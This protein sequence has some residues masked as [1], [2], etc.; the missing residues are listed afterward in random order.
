MKRSS[1]CSL[2]EWVPVS[3][4]EP[5][6]LLLLVLP[7]PRRSGAGASAPRPGQGTGTGSSSG[8]SARLCL[9]PASDRLPWEDS[10]EVDSV[11]EVYREGIFGSERLDFLL[12]KK[13]EGC[14]APSHLARDPWPRSVLG[15]PLSVLGGRLAMGSLC[16]QE[17]PKFRVLPPPL[18]TFL[19]HVGKRRPEEGGD[20]VAGEEADPAGDE[21]HA[22][23][24]PVLV[25]AEDADPF[26]L[27][28]LQLVR[29]VSRVGVESHA[30]AERGCEGRQ[31]CRAGRLEPPGAAGS[32]R[33]GEDAAGSARSLSSPSSTE[34][35]VERPAASGQ[36]GYEHTKS[37]QEWRT[38]QLRRMVSGPEVPAQGDKRWGGGSC[39][40][41]PP[42][43][44]QKH[45][46]GP[47]KY[48]S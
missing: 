45:G 37:R 2:G 36:R 44:H 30:P 25:L 26:S 47:D 34:R 31:S 28:Q 22:P 15:G 40:S 27:L 16:K 39:C 19:P 32:K 42:A 8:R 35:S 7:R 6:D 46:S 14:W 11:H 18:S 23:Q 12:E 38:K 13:G 48:L 3:L 41:A 21:G 1:R 20:I 10:D 5:P 43:L 17:D 24:P 9:G 29:S 4:P 33:A